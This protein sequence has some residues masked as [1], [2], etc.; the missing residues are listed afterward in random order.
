MN[1]EQ[2][3]TDITATT[4][5]SSDIRTTGTETTTITETVT[6]NMETYTTASVAVT[7]NIDYTNHLETLTTVNLLIFCILACMLGVMI[8]N[9]FMNRWR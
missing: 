6:A 8:F 3:T 5:E 1:D 4:A 2:T 7:E 9:Q